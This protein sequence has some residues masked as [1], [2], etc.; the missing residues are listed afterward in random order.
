MFLEEDI[1]S[2]YGGRGQVQVIHLLNYIDEET[3]YLLGQRAI[4]K[5]VIVQSASDW[6]DNHSPYQHFNE[7]AIEADEENEPVLQEAQI[8][9]TGTPNSSYTADHELTS[10]MNGENSCK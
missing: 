7:D 5:W 1:I 9:P 3:A 6:T 10:L 8:S 4:L 2:S